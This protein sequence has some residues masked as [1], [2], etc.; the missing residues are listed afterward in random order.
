MSDKRRVVIVGAGPGGLACAM[1]LAK[2]GVPTTVL[3][4]QNTVGGRTSNFGGQ[5]FTFDLG[6]TFFLYPRVLAEIFR[7]VGRDL[8]REVPMTRLDPQYHL[9]FGSGGDLRCTPDLDAMTQQIAQLD[10]EDA[11]QFGR[12]LNENR[13]KLARFRP[14]LERPFLSLRD[15]LSWDMIKLMPLLRPWL[16][17]DDELSRYFR[18]PRVRLALSFQSKYLGMSPFQCPS[19]FS[20]LSFLEYEHGVWHPTGG[21]GAVSRKMAEVAQELGAEIRLNEDVT[22][23]LFEGRRAVGVQTTRGEYRADALVINADFARAMTRLIPNHLRKRWNDQR[24]AKKRFSCSTFMLY[25]GVEGINHDVAHHTIYMSQDYEQNLKD[26]ETEHRLSEDPSFYVQNASV[27]DSTLAPPG[28]STLYV[29]LPVSHQ[30]PN[31]DW[32][33]ETPRYRTLALRQL[34]KIGLRDLESRIRWERVVTPADWD[35]GYQIHLGATFNL[36]HNLGQMLHLRPRNR[37]EEFEGIYLTGGGTHPGSGLPV[38][39]ESARITSRLILQD[40]QLPHDHCKVEFC[41]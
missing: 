30:H 8:F 40:W 4:R 13:E 18:D 21:C 31:I 41:L 27:T 26:I 35:A 15:V 17:L 1:L 11:K 24:I 7:A 10:A 14:A 34:E 29:L 6:P 28:H 22:Q 19:L 36:A 20:I 32:T 25:L 23:I 12:F 33:Q 39:Y 38:I 9:K 2:A 16:S 3:E 37:F 5:G